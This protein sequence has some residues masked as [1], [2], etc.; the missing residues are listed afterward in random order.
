MGMRCCKSSPLWRCPLQL[1]GQIHSFQPGCCCYGLCSSLTWGFICSLGC[2]NMAQ[3][4]FFFFFPS[5]FFLRLSQLL[6]CWKRQELGAPR[7][8]GVI[9][10]QEK[11]P[12]GGSRAGPWCCTKHPLGARASLRAFVPGSPSQIP[13][14]VTFLCR[15]RLY[16]NFFIPL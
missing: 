2:Q 12:L 3:K 7:R 16:F 6:S 1:R 14:L 9:L 4:G 11:Q 13:P 10:T 5:L 15:K 8:M